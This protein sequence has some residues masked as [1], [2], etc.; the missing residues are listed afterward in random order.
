MITN[1]SENVEVF[2][3]STSQLMKLKSEERNNDHMEAYKKLL[4]VPKW[5][6]EIQLKLMTTKYISEY[7]AYFPELNNDAFNCQIV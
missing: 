3:A 7:A 4:Q 2:Y 6:E 1:H 5:P